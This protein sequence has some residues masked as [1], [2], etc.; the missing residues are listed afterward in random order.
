MPTLELSIEQG[1]LVAG[2][3]HA[4][5][6]QV[7]QETAIKKTTAAAKA[8]E[9]ENNRAAAAE[10]KRH[11]DAMRMREADDAAQK[12][13]HAER[14]RMY[15][16][17]FANQDRQRRNIEEIIASERAYVAQLQEVRRQEAQMFQQAAQREGHAAFYGGQ[18]SARVGPDPVTAG[19]ARWNTEK[20]DARAKADAR[21]AASQ[22]AARAQVQDFLDTSFFMPPH[23]RGQPGNP[24]AGV[25]TKG[26]QFDLAAKAS[27]EAEKA[28]KK[29]NAWL[30]QLASGSTTA[31]AQIGNLAAQIIGFGSAA[32]VAVKV[33]TTAKEALD[34][35]QQQRQAGADV[36][37]SDFEIMRE[38]SEVSEPGQAKGRFAKYQELKKTLG[39]QS[40][41][42][43]LE[44][45]IAT[46]NE[47][48]VNRFAATQGGMDPALAMS[49]G[50][51]LETLF[52]GSVNELQ[53]ANMVLEASR[54]S[55][56]KV[57]EFAPNAATAAVGGSMAGSSA[58]ETLAVMSVMSDVLKNPE[59][60]SQRMQYLGTRGKYMGIESHDKGLMAMMEELS[61]MPAEER[62]NPKYAG[63]RIQILSFVDKMNE[64]RAAIREREREIA[65]AQRRAGGASSN[66]AIAHREFMGLPGAG[67]L[68]S[69][70]AT[71]GE[72]ADVLRENYGPG[73]L[74][75]EATRSRT[76]TRSVRAR[77]SAITRG[78]EDRAAGIGE[79]AGGSERSAM[80]GGLVGNIAGGG[81]YNPVNIFLQMIGLQEKTNEI[82]VKIDQKTVPASKPAPPANGG[83]RR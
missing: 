44:K 74:R 37:K 31:S 60:V 25:S 65:D 55:R 70:R 57:A 53:G 15:Q 62:K 19:F 13:A 4:E 28:A 34:F 6:A 61:A 39:P 17:L 64:N 9:E 82:L 48:S 38:I 32:G 59:E 5:Q 12:R 52:G 45:A 46:G 40:A 24:M 10:N 2:L 21:Y 14:Q 23:M 83:G 81:R 77:E 79:W 58:A 36:I 76:R 54:K 26:S 1:K 73:Q 66:L 47:G 71:A 63:E 78:I 33:L 68:L 69:S 67:E 50:S 75:T 80:A 49:V 18:Y 27:K 20:A 8:W 43:L 35:A 16:E 30:Q 51:H 22:A 72:E 29:H 56:W 42:G 41:W 11:A 7:K 3:L